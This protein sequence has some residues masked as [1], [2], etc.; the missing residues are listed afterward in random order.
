[1]TIMRRHKDLRPFNA[2]HENQGCK[3]YT[4][5]YFIKFEFIHLFDVLRTSS[6][7]QSGVTPH[8]KN[9]LPLISQQR[10]FLK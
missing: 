2:S 10:V 6:H 5:E 1:V 7:H 4:S 8:F 9:Y 3:Q